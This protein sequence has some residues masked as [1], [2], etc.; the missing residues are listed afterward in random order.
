MTTRQEL[1]QRREAFRRENAD[2][3]FANPDGLL[4]REVKEIIASPFVRRALA[5]ELPGK[6]LR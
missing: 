4:A 5:A 1:E 3:L 6:V 2:R